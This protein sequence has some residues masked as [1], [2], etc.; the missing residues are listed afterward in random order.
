MPS[1]VGEPGK[2]DV[3]PATSLRVV[4]AAC[5]SRRSSRRGRRTSTSPVI[6]VVAR[7]R[8]R[9]ARAGRWPRCRRGRHVL[10]R[11]VRARR[12]RSTTRCS[13]R[14]C[15]QPSLPFARRQGAVARSSAS[16]D[17]DL[18]PREARAT[19][20]LRARAA[21]QRRPCGARRA[22]RPSARGAR[23][24]LHRDRDRQPQGQSA[25]HQRRPRTRCSPSTSSTSPVIPRRTRSTVCSRSSASGSRRGRP[26]VRFVVYGAAR[27]AASSAP[28]RARSR[29][30]SIARAHY[31]AIRD[32]A[33][34]HPVADDDATSSSCRS[35][36]IA[37]I[38]RAADDVVLLATKSQDTLARRGARVRARPHPGRCRSR[39][40]SRTSRCCLR[41]FANVYAVCVMSPTAHIE[42]GVVQRVVGPIERPARHRPLP[43]GR[44]R[45]PRPPS[46]SAL[47]A[48]TFHSVPAPD[49]MRW[50]YTKL[51]MNLGNA[52][53]AIVRTVG[54]ASWS[55]ST[56]AGAKRT[57]PAHGGHRLRVARRRQGAARR[58]ACRPADRRRARAVARRGRASPVAPGR[59][60][61]TT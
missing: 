31:E 8:P 14:C 61:P 19:R 40:V 23:R 59:S 39:T 52:I 36:A 37:R 29:R 12:W 16:R 35:S 45:R 28:A 33:A 5:A 17:A 42:P 10:Q 6:D 43:A 53:E 49:I 18:G 54:T 48:S 47:T 44:R 11:R 22:V 7:A 27:S 51:L 4:R 38:D 57:V 55:R 21:L 20:P 60:R 3:G 25:R 56:L 24:P 32:R 15:S 13:R 34:A 9:P 46:S 41:S 50:K 2:R 30:C 1:L 26:R 58:P